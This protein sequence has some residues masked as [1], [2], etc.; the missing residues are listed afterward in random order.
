MAK[1]TLWTALEGIED[2]RTRKGRRYRLPAVIAIALRA[3]LPGSNDLMAIFRW[4]G[5]CR[6][7]RYRRSASTGSAKKAPCHAT[8]HYVFQSISG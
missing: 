8:V 3:M 4:G 2:R 1:G 6:R 5:V 7:R